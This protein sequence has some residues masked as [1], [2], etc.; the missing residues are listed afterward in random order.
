MSELYKT[1]PN[2]VPKP[3]AWGRTVEDPTYFFLCEYLNISDRLPDPAKLATQIADLHKSSVSPTGKFGFHV[4]TY[5]GKL[6][7]VTD[8]DNSWP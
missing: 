4:P 8:W 1:K 2:L 3:I 6:P 7:Q 5:D